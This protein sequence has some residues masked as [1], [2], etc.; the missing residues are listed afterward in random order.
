MKTSKSTVASD[1]C[2]SHAQIFA[3]PVAGECAASPDWPAIEADYRA[4][5]M[6]IREVARFHDVPESSLRDRAKAEAWQR[7]ARHIT[8]AELTAAGGAP[9]SSK[10]QRP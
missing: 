8:D 3:S 10:G 2:R 9:L 5:S 7:T 1:R 4:G 6:S